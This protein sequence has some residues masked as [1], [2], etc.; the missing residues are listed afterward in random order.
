MHIRQYKP[1]LILVDGLINNIIN[2]MKLNTLVAYIYN[3]STLEIHVKGEPSD[4]RLHIYHV[5]SGPWRWVNITLLRYSWKD[6]HQLNTVSSI[7]A[8]YFESPKLSSY[9]KSS[10]RGKQATYSTHI[11][12]SSVEIWTIKWI[13]DKTN[14]LE[15]G[16]RT[17]YM[18]KIGLYEE[19]LGN[20]R[21]PQWE[22]LNLQIQ[23]LKLQVAK[24]GRS[25]TVYIWP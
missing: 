4:L 24:L 1:S 11:Q 22:K 8:L 25:E 7:I 13:V 18:D 12:K 3:L 17:L 2:Y 15:L 21:E 10:K 19:N 5:L 16:N 9:G 20:W 23:V 6:W 14:F